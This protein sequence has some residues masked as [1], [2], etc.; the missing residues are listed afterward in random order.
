MAVFTLFIHILMTVPKLIVACLTAMAVS[1]PTIA[2]QNDNL[3]FISDTLGPVH[4]WRI[5]PRVLLE[6]CSIQL[7][8]MAGAMRET[9]DVWSRKNESLI[10][11]IDVTVEKV[12]PLYASAL[13]I[14][15]SDA[16]TSIDDFTTQLVIENY[17]GDKRFSGSQVCTDYGVIVSGLSA[18]GRTAVVRGQLYS[19]ESTLL[20]LERESLHVNMPH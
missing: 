1:P 3:A 4:A 18:H 5:I 19:I 11:L 20:A 7:P 10:S 16:K 17:F 12:V 13:S 15:N 8:Q 2:A 9:Y 6:K 14:S